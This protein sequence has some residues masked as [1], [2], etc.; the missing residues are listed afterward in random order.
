LFDF[1]EDKID[2]PTAV[3]LIQQNTRNYAKRQMTWFKK[4][5]N[6][7]W[8]DPTEKEKIIHFLQSKVSNC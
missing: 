2:L 1:I 5:E 3:S 6:I 4:D 7:H 8:F